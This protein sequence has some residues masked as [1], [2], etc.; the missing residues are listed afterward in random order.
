MTLAEAPAAGPPGPGAAPPPAGPRPWPRAAVLLRAV[1]VAG[2]VLLGVGL[3]TLGSRS[4]TYV[5]LRAGV[6]DGS[7]DR[8]LVEGGWTGPGRGQATARVTWRD[9]VVRR[10][11]EVVES[12][13]RARV[14]ERREGQVRVLPGTV[15]EDLADLAP[16]VEVS[17]GP[18]PTG[19]AGGWWLPGWLSLVVLGWS[20]WTALWVLASPPPW[21]MTR[22]ATLW[23]TLL[24]GP[25]GLAAYL[26]LAGPVPGVPAPRTA[27]P[28]LA[29]G[30][31]FL[32]ALVLG[33]LLDW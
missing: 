20:I 6:A 10:T 22:W 19:G 4:G 14:R 11:A 18:G 3:L 15:A 12:S 8:V 5:D 29:G 23:L 9:G 13:P 16:D 31:A 26:L 27:R 30:W 25:I 1:L 33:A 28:A 32:L 7:V 17:R 24:G 2:W 21:R